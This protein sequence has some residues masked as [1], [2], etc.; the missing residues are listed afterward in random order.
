MIE[1]GG[2]QGSHAQLSLETAL[3]DLTKL[4][5]GG[6]QPGPFLIP[7]FLDSETE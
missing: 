4:G 6:L 2:R 7:V 1:C 5:G 3:W